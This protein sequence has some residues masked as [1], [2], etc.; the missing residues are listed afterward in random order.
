MKRLLLIRHAKSDWED[1]NMADFD[2]PLNPRGLGN[3]PE[4]G[5]RLL[6]RGLKPELF[7]SSPAKRALTTAISI[8][9]VFRIKKKSIQQEKNI[10]EASAS[11]LLKIVNGFDNNYD[12]IAMVG[13]NPGFTDLA[14]NLCDCDIYNIPTCGM[15]LLEFTFADWKMVSAQTG[16]MKLFDYPKKEFEI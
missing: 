7:V 10:Y 12:F 4:M 11:S 3:A 9:E 2:R 6:K 13:H 15:V 5:M 1:R 16:E 14:V 8:A